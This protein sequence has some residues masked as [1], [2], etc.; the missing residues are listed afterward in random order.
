MSEKESRFLLDMKIQEII[1]KVNIYN[2]TIENK[3]EKN[4]YDMAIVLSHPIREREKKVALGRRS[5]LGNVV[6]A[7]I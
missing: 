6:H 3:Y 1:C 5:K 4:C 7:I 2:T